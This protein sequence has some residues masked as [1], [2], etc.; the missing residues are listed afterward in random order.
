MTDEEKAIL[1]N[2]TQRLAGIEEAARTS[3]NG[4]RELLIRID[5]RVGQIKN[6]DIPA[7]H[8][9]LDKLNNFKDKIETQVTRNSTLIKVIMGVIGLGGAATGITKLTPMW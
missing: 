4:E 7:V 2:M 8:A 6:T 1:L 9:R 3:R 5:E